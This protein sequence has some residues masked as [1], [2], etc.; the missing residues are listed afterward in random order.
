MSMEQC[1]IYKTELSNTPNTKEESI[2]NLQECIFDTIFKCEK[3]Y[4]YSDLKK[5]Y[6]PGL[7]D[8]PKETASSLDIY[9][10][11]RYIKQ[12]QFLPSYQ[13]TDLEWS[14][15]C[16]IFGIDIQLYHAFSYEKTNLI[17]AEQQRQWYVKKIL[18]KKVKPIFTLSKKDGT[19]LQCPCLLYDNK[20]FIIGNNFV[21]NKLE[22][23]ETIVNSKLICWI[24]YRHGKFFFPGCPDLDVPPFMIKR[25]S[26]QYNDYTDPIVYHC[27]NDI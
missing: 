27:T 4:S 18:R 20:Y 9:N 1:I 2:R 12:K 8:D 24:N 14:I 23:Q 6:V 11:I 26:F 5:Y 3:Q 16:S 13:G 22:F 15:F 21:C 7:K 19:R 25:E 10:A 17:Q